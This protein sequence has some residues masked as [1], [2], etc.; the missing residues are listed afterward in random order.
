[1]GIYGL[2]Y[3]LYHPGGEWNGMDWLYSFD[4]TVTY[5]KPKCSGSNRKLDGLN[6]AFRSAQSFILSCDE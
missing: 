3:S 4:F 5:S 1:M 2:T 6:I